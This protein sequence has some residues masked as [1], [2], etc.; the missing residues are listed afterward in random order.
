MPLGIL[1][2]VDAERLSFEVKRGDVII[3][4]SDG[5]LVGEEESP[6]LPS[7]LTDEW[8]DDLNYMA[9]KIISRARAKGSRDDISVVI[10]S[11]V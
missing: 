5:V 3:M 4:V 7:L 6:W 2:T 9:K 8:D 11:V 10:T 1:E